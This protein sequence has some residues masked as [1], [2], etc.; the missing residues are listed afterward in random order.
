MRI[1][2]FTGHIKNVVLLSLKNFCSAF[3]RFFYHP[4]QH[5]NVGSTLFQRCG[6]TLKMKKNPTSD[7]QRCTTLIQRQCLTLKQRRNNNMQRGNNVAQRW[8]NVETTLFQLSVD[9]SWSYIESN[10]ASDDCGLWDSWMHVKYTNSFSS[11]KWEN[12][13]LYINHSTTNEISNNFL[14]VVHI[15]IHNVEAVVQ[16]CSIKKVFLEIF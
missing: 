2:K 12:F 3:C 10:R 14:T 7:F 11:A 1:Y 15:V 13:L 4:R 8:Y 16:R 5:F 9:V 6:T